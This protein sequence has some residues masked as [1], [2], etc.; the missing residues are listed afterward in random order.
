M[1]M[2]EQSLRILF[3]TQDMSEVKNYLITQWS[4]I[5]QGG[6]SLPLK[7]FIFRKE[8]KFGKYGPHS[9][10]PGSIVASKQVTLDEMAVPPYRW[11]VPYVVVCGNPKASL[12]E[13]VVA[14]EEY[15]R[16]GSSLRINSTYYIAKCINP[17]LNRILSLCGADVALW[18]RQMPK[19]KIRIRHI[20]YEDYEHAAN[21]CKLTR[22]KNT[23][24]Q[25]SMDR[26]TIKGLCEVCGADAEPNKSLCANCLD[27]PSNALIV[28][29]QRLNISQDG[30]RHLSL[31]CQNCSRKDQ[32]ATFY[33]RKQMVG[34]N[35]CS[36]LDCAV[37]FERCRVVTRIED[38]LITLD[39]I[40]GSVRNQS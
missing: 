10:P 12:Y 39:E 37:F 33:T 9:Q 19:P 26:Y 36:S 6:D 38:C 1:K 30:D 24:K 31:L 23:L 15:L 28:I 18:Y 40:S 34:P 4:K 32:S 16:R 35:C 11:R 27:N 21:T 14:P 3:E 8:V 7:D 5:H 17:S 22:P 25:Q 2:Q 13:L 29:L 20:S